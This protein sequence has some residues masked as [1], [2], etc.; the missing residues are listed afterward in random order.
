MATSCQNCGCEPCECTYPDPVA[1]VIAT[2]D[3]DV[4]N[5]PPADTPWNHAESLLV[6][7][8]WPS[9]SGTVDVTVEDTAK[10]SRAPALV[11]IRDAAGGDHGWLQIDS[12]VDATTLRLLEVGTFG[13]RNP[14]AT[15]PITGDAD[16]VIVQLGADFFPLVGGDYG[17]LSIVAADIALATITGAQIAADTID[18]TKII[19][20]ATLLSIPAAD[21]GTASGIVNVGDLATY[22]LAQWGP[23]ASPVYTVSGVAGEWIFVMLT[24]DLGA[25]IGVTS[26]GAADTKLQILYTANGATATEKMKTIELTV[27]QG[28]LQR[29]NAKCFGV[30]KFDSDGDVDFQLEA[31]GEAIV[32]ATGGSRGALRRRNFH[33]I[34]FYKD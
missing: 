27:H 32:P 21:G 15:T 12:R 6:A 8:S 16:S 17:P 7:F 33:H 13:G 26:A 3:P 5:P 11:W 20:P 19:D 30:W 2:F 18:F 22:G 34:M 10:F 29:T 24:A 25:D 23:I 31:Y 1:P 14:V 4:Q 28:L 9:A